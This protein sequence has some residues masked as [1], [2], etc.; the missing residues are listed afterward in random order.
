MRPGGG[1]GGDISNGLGM[2]LEEFDPSEYIL[3]FTFPPPAAT[4]EDSLGIPFGDGNEDTCWPS[5]Q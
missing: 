4:L 5:L 3:S 1:G 2:R